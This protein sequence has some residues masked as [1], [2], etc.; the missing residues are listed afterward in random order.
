MG[1]SCLRSPGAGGSARCTSHSPPRHTGRRGRS[2][3]A[4]NRNKQTNR[5]ALCSGRAP[6]RRAPLTHSS[7]CCAVKSLPPL[8]SYSEVDRLRELVADAAAGRR[9]WLQGGDCAERFADCTAPAVARRLRLLMQM[10]LVLAWGSRTRVVR[11]A[12]MAGQY[13]KP[14]SSTTEV[15]ADGRRV[16]AFRGDNINSFHDV[17][18]EGREPDA[19]RLLKGYFCSA[20]T[21]NFARALVSEGFGGVPA[22]EK[23]HERWLLR[24]TR[25]HSGGVADGARDGTGAAEGEGGAGDE[26]LRGPRGGEYDEIVASI[27]KALEFARMVGSDD[28]PTHAVSGAGSSRADPLMRAGAAETFM[29]HEGLLLAY[30]EALTRRCPANDAHYD[31]STHFLWLGDRTRQVD[32]AHV[33][34]MRGLANPVGVKL[35]PT[36]D[37][38]EVAALLER[39]WPDPVAQPGKVV[40]ITRLG[41]G[42]VRE[43]LPPLVRAVQELRPMRPVLWVCDPMHGNT[44]VSPSGLKTRAFETVLSEIRTSMDVLSSLGERLGGLHLELVGDDVTECHGGPEGLTEDDV[45]RRYTSYCDPRLNEAQSMELAFQVAAMLRR[46]GTAA[47]AAG[48]SSAEDAKVRVAEHLASAYADEDYESAEETRAEGAVAEGASEASAECASSPCGAA[49]P[50]DEPLYAGGK[51]Q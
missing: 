7:P 39:L 29:S 37:P 41:A 6:R 2:A 45:G 1:S 18:A 8:V 34:F 35:G 51:G 5:L 38:K 16:P 21:L 27:T 32:Y 44:T 19:S 11:V 22:V 24:R 12:R 14:R 33:E 13:S 15:L 47:A 25:K 20:A 28:E 26:R 4:N 23:W 50:L 42:R 31:L 10:S 30:E 17:T 36:A 46:Q 48:A 3:L 40:L 43:L 9:F 49:G